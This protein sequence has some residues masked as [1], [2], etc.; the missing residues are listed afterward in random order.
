M[1]VYQIG[2]INAPEAAVDGTTNI[3]FRLFMKST[4]LEITAY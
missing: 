3:R 2:F 1:R 4:Q